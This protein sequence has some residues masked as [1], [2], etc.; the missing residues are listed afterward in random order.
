[1]KMKRFVPIVAVAVCVATAGCAPEVGPN[2]V[3]VVGDGPLECGR[4]AAGI[5]AVQGAQAMSPLVGEKVEVEARISAKF[6][7][8]LGGFYLASEPGSEDADPATSE[9]IFV[10]H[11]DKLDWPVGSRVRVRATVAELGAAPDTQTALIEVAQLVR[12]EDKPIALAP[13]AIAGA[14]QAATD[15][16][17]LAADTVAVLRGAVYF[18]QCPMWST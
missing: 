5:A 4:L 7:D 13:R 2:G 14:G 9:G 15:W 11:A 17:R 1:M 10:R 18:S 6:V 3:P 8:G 12:C 16:E